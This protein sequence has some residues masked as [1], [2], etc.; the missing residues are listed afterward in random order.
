MVLV[1]DGRSLRLGDVIK[2]ATN[3]EKVK[4][5]SDAEKNVVQAREYLQYL[6]KSGDTVYGI[7]TGVGDLANVKID[8]GKLS[9]LQLNIVRSH[10]AGYGNPANPE[11]VRATML[12][13]AN[14]LLRGNS[15]IRLEVI[16]AI[17]D[18]LNSDVIPVVPEKGSIGASGDLAPLAHIALT[19]IGEGKA[20]YKNEEVDSPKAL[21]DAKIEPVILEP[22]E[23]LS[24]IN[25]CHYSTAILTLQ[26]ERVKN[27]LAY[28]CIAEA[29]LVQVLSS[30]LSPFD[31]RLQNVRPHKGQIEVAE[32]VRR[33]L[34]GSKVSREDAKKPQD[35]YS[36]RCYPQVAGAVVDTIKNAQS[37][38]EI[39]MNSSVDNP[40]LFADEGVY[41]S[42]G[43]FHGQPVAFASDF[44]SISTTALSALMER[45]LSRILDSKLS[46]LPAFLSDDAGFRAGYMIAQYTATALL[47]ESRVLSH[48][49]S[50]EAIPVS[51]GQEDSQSMAPVCAMKLRDIVCNAEVIC[52]ILMMCLAQAIDLAGIRDDLG[53]PLR[54]VY[55]VIRSNVQFYNDDRPIS[56][57]IKVMAKLVRSGA[58]VKATGVDIEEMLFG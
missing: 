44:S 31:S 27:L 51:A 48:P 25:G 18:M 46:G 45:Q 19:L 33:L 30:P 38:C 5:S 7:N 12:I 36:I 55:D 57:D 15:G 58:I 26:I 22:K 35:A 10:S 49:A 54:G 6:V 29:V 32:I 24:L 1:I 11:T 50:I 39:E 9:E 3:G 43:N 2:V 47:S 8:Q 41:I 40:L 16:R 53:K 56:D 42:G 34:K 52:G 4:I 28:S 23:G 21:K 13:L 20:I 14:S 37:V 17:V